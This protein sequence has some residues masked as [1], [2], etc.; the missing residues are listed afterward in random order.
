[1]GSAPNLFELQ[2]AK[3]GFDPVKF[4]EGLGR[5]EFRTKA[6]FFLKEIDLSMNSVGSSE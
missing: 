5:E 3:V 2:L 6:S 4:F 1:M